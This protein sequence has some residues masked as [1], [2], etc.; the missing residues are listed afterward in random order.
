[1]TIGPVA[2][3]GDKRQAF[4]RSLALA[5]LSLGGE[6]RVGVLSNFLVEDGS[7][8]AYDLISFVKVPTSVPVEGIIPG[9]QLAAFVKHSDHGELVVE[10][11]HHS[12]KL[13]VGKSKVELVV[14][15]GE[16]FPRPPDLSSA[17][18]AMRMPASS[19]RLL[20]KSLRYVNKN[21]D[22]GWQSTIV[23]RPGDPIQAFSTSGIS[24]LR[25]DLPG[26]TKATDDFFLPGS[27]V[28]HAIMMARQVDEDT[29]VQ[30]LRGKSASGVSWVA[31]RIPKVGLA[32]AS[33]DENWKA[34]DFDRIIRVF[35]D[36]K[37]NIELDDAFVQFMVKAAVA[38]R[39]MGSTYC[40]I[41][42][43]GGGKVTMSTDLVGGQAVYEDETSYAG[44]EPIEVK[45]NP[46]LIR[47][48]LPTHET[49]VVD[50]RGVGLFGEGS[51]FLAAAYG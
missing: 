26:T 6:S 25:L 43:D 24:L 51:I 7:L 10:P 12:V 46:E 44:G 8:Y 14:E 39:R 47:T 38:T 35:S 29:E 37:A 4:S 3:D 2:L 13:K 19:V 50:D 5:S 34:G 20:V 17:K 42:F 32:A 36:G 9:K 33:V 15:D 40:L 27:I 23:I 22:S 21:P 1:M 16:D 28:R 49:M 48:N 18:V 31:V 30:F 45:M 11:G 41:S